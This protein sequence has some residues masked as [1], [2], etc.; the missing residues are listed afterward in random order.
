MLSQDKLMKLY[1]LANGGKVNQPEKT[2]KPVDLSSYK[3]KL[4]VKRGSYSDP[5]TAWH[6]WMDESR[7]DITSD[8]SEE[9]WN[10]VEQEYPGPQDVA[11][12][13]IRS[14]FRENLPSEPSAREVDLRNRMQTAPSWMQDELAPEMASTSS[15]VAI[16]NTAKSK[17]IYTMSL[18]NKLS[19]LDFSQ[20]DL[21]VPIDIHL[22][23]I[24]ALEAL[25]MLDSASIVNGR[26]CIANENGQVEP[27]FNM[28]SKPEV[29]QVLSQDSAELS[30]VMNI[31]KKIVMPIIS[32]ATSNSRDMGSMDNRAAGG[33]AINSL[34]SGDIPVDQWGDM[35]SMID[36]DGISAGVEGMANKTPFMSTEEINSTAMDISNRYGA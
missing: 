24:V 3:R 21:D 33:A 9:M 25:N 16:Q 6:K 15:K 4:A 28:L 13:E 29:Q 23:E 34:K 36:G 10:M 35:L 19:K 14:K 32:K 26:L 18:E 12:N 20:L 1:S 2:K 5:V 22:Q 11:R 30:T 31:A 7:S 17:A 27:A 8:N